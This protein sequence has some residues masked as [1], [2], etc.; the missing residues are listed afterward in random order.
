MTHT[1]F[2]KSV[3]GGGGSKIAKFPMANVSRSY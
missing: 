1:Q 3:G 2:Q